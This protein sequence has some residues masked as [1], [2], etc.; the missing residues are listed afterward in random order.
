MESLVHISTSVGKI[1]MKALKLKR[2]I[3]M[4]KRKPKPK[5]R[6]KPKLTYGGY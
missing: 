2:R 1:Q 6:P 4:A 3:K 5:P